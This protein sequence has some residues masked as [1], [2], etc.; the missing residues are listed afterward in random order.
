MAVSVRG[1]LR[2]VHVVADAGE[3]LKVRL[4][5]VARLLAADAQLVREAERR[6]AVD[7]AEV[8]RLGAAAHLAR[9]VLH[10]HAEHFRCRHRVNVEA[11]GEGLLQL[12]NVGDVREHAQLDL[13]IVGRDE[14]H[15]RRRR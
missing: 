5:V 13:R 1:L 8:D 10:R 14:L 3:A 4:D 9:H 6:D 15:A 11:F 7:D 12:R 2:R